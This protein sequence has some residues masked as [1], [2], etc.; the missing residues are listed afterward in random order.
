MW[1]DILLMLSEY[2]TYLLPTT[3]GVLTATVIPLLIKKFTETKLGTSIDKIVNDTE[4]KLSS[5]DERIFKE[6]K[7]L[8]NKVDIMRG[9]APE[10]SDEDI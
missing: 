4:E 3:T 9:R 8:N 7:K 1:E 10:D 5:H 2:G 6:L